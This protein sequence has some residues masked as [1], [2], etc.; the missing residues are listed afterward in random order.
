MELA[1]GLLGSNV[2]R[3]QLCNMRVS[4]RNGWVDSS[5]G[6]RCFGENINHVNDLGVNGPVSLKIGHRAPAPFSGDRK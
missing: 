4:Q 1:V 3:A 2:F 6:I 5:Q